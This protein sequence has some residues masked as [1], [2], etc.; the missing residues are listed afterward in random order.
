M[1]YLDANILYAGVVNVKDQTDSVARLLARNEL[2]HVSSLAD[3]EARKALLTQ[4]ANDDHVALLDS[5][6]SSKCKMNTGWD[7]AISH[8]L[9]VA[10]QFKQRLWVDSADTMHVGWALALGA[11]IFA[12]FPLEV[13]G[14]G[15][16]GGATL[17]EGDGRQ[18]PETFSSGT[19]AAISTEDSII[20]CLVGD[21]SS[22]I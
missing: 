1:I 11:D 19:C 18:S 17:E 9:K 21:A 16:K 3:Y 2:F 4:G 15:N 13:V 12:S 7:A 8:S 22:K 20:D 6:L 5:L 10:R 14:L